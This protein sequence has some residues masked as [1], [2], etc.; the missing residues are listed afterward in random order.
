MTLNTRVQVR[1]F[2]L[3]EAETRRIQRHLRS[4]SRRLAESPD[5]VAVLLLDWHP[6]QRQVKARFRVRLGHLGGHFVSRTSAETADS[7]ARLAIE[8]VKRQIERHMAHLRGEPEFSKLS[9]QP[10]LDVEIP[11]ED[12]PPKGPKA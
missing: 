7:A 10:A 4:L 3:N 1:D 12:V 5:P 11:S 2:A 9:Q 8:D 6:D